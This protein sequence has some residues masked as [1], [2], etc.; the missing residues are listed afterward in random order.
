MIHRVQ[1][2]VAIEHVDIHVVTRGIEKGIEYV[3]EIRDSIYLY[4][5]KSF[6]Y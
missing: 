3:A 2:R 4:S 6:R 1:Q 5:A